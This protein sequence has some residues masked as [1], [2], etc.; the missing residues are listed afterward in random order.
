ME[1]PNDFFY[2]HICH[3]CKIKLPTIKTCSGCRLISYCSQMHQKEDWKHHKS[4][5]LCVR[6]YLKEHNL[7]SLFV[8]PSE[9]ADEWKTNILSV[10]C[11]VELDLERPLRAFEKQM[12]F[13]PDV[14][15]VCYVTNLETNHYCENC[16]CVKYCSEEHKILHLNKHETDCST[17]K[18][19]YEIDKI[20]FE[21]Q[22]SEV[23]LDVPHCNGLKF[24]D[25]MEDFLSDYFPNSPDVSK[26]ILSEHYSG[27]LSLLSVINS[28]K[29]ICWKNELNIHIIG[30]SDYEQ[31]VLMTIEIL[32]H[33]FSNLEKLNLSLI[34][35]EICENYLEP[36]LCEECNKVKKL[37]IYKEKKLYHHYWK[38][39]AC[40]APDVIF[41]YNCGFSEV[42]NP[43]EN[44]WTESINDIWNMKNVMFAFTSYTESEA[45]TDFSL[46]LDKKPETKVGIEFPM[47]SCQNPFKSLRPY[48]NPEFFES[49]FFY[50]NY[51]ITMIELKD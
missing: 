19:C 32:F 21:S 7:K 10:M 30:A 42:M 20:C 29:N 1:K 47:V 25:S 18:I 33:R 46:V 22:L 23:N 39:S 27:A 3:I 12:F 38:H 28:S 43:E 14:C 41:S 9:N 37:T 36:V 2:H 34:G 13:Y 31:S 15:P 4:F 6:N 8:A 11:A 49:I 35:P 50:N 44:S 5:C 40:A 48:R 24:P 51:Y 45:K 16:H 26:I 17:F